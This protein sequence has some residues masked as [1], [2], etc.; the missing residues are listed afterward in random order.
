[1]DFNFAGSHVW[2]AEVPHLKVPRRGDFSFPGMV[3][4]KVEVPPTLSTI[5]G[6]SRWPDP[7]VEHNVYCEYLSTWATSECRVVGG[8][9]AESA[10]HI[11]F[12]P[13]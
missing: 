6:G 4:C 2:E 12:G 1:M 7:A 5:L 8:G 11:I 9:G 13:N 10:V 3:A